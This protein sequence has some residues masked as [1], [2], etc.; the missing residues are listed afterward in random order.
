MWNED[1]AK[2]CSEYGVKQADIAKLCGI[3]PK[4]F[5]AIKNGRRNCSKSLKKKIEVNI[6]KFN[7]KYEL[8]AIYDYVRVR[9]STH[10]HVHI[11]TDVLLMK[12][13]FFVLEPIGF[14]GY[15]SQY[16][17]SDIS[18][19]IAPE[20][21]KRGTLLELKGK[22]CRRFEYLLKA[23]KRTWND[24]FVSCFANNGVFKRL[25]IAIN[26]TKGIIDIE[27][28]SRKAGT[29]EC[30]M[31]FTT[32]NRL[33]SSENLTSEIVDGKLGEGKTLY[34]GSM[35]SEIY[36]C[37]YEK[38]YEQYIKNGIP[39]ED[40]DVKNRFEIRL[41]ND[42]ALA[43]LS[44]LITYD[45]IE[46]TAFGIINRYLCFYERDDSKPFEDWEIDYRWNWFI[47]DGREKIKLTMQP[48]PYTIEKTQRWIVNQVAPS[49]SLLDK[50]DK[51]EGTHLVDDIRRVKLPDKQRRLYEQYTSSVYDVILSD[52]YVDDKQDLQIPNRKENFDKYAELEQLLRSAYAELKDREEEIALL[53]K[54]LDVEDYFI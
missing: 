47:G 52:D 17:F 45:D 40:A 18:I 31:I 1:I 49:I 2:K 26:D 12:P 14:Y 39:I 32:I 41:K 48:E 37:I 15:K 20:D 23:Q 9:F 34:L 8:Y 28:L 50:I 13:E 16:V 24:F 7:P 43:A 11:M 22:G 44:D 19:M 25:D 53:K 10:D 5:S 27:E 51:F 38:D 36:F 46:R 30:Q 42:R 35:H 21:D 4:T 33:S 3:H 54:R 29:D 6:E